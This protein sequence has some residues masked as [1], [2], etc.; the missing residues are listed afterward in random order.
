[1]A[2][3]PGSTVYIPGHYLL[4]IGSAYSKPPPALPQPT[5]KIRLLLSPYLS[6]H[7]INPQSNPFTTPYPSYLSITLSVSRPARIFKAKSLRDNL[8]HQG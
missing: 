1:M 7:Y 6:T 8:G 2:R 4:D 5:P 3:I